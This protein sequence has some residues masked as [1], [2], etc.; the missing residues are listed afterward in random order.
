MRIALLTVMLC[1]AAAPQEEVAKVCSD[2]EKVKKLSRKISPE[3]R[4]KIEK[5]LGQ[6]LEDADLS[7]ALYE[8]Y[9]TVPS[10]SGQEKTRCVVCF[11][12]VKGPKGA[13]RIGVASAT[14]ENTLH[15]VRVLQNGDD[16]AVESK[17]FLAQFEGLEYTESLY[18]APSVLEEA[19]KKAAGGDK[20]LGALVRMN[21]LM[22]AMGP[23][24]ERV[25]HK[26]DA[27]DKSGAT[28][29]AAMEK[30]FEETAKL[31]AGASFLK[32]AQQTRFKDYAEGTRKDLAELKALFS[33][34]KFED[35][36]RKAGEVDAARCAKCHGA[37]RRA[38][39]E[40]RLEN[41]IGNGYFSTR[42]DVTAPEKGLE[43]LT[44][45]VATGIRKAILLSAEA[46]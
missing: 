45:A 41:G 43:P 18:S 32:P 31:V 34:G 42:L 35:A 19:L 14:M 17:G 9:S 26:I 10:V 23:G 37:S 27:K 30:D 39:R 36:Y 16:K 40:S 12:T 46:K 44:Q 38:F 24:W 4:Q 11:V 1:G 29:A 13:V 33:G 6:K 25:M 20:S 2:A 15:A 28:E 5:A 21:G 7:P 8:C 3:A 22:R